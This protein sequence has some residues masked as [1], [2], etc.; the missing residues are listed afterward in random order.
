MYVLHFYEIKKLEYFTFF[1][2]VMQFKKK[3]FMII[4]MGGLSNPLRLF[5][6]QDGRL[7]V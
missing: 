1:C 6:P 5:P 2:F 3:K 7:R 4:S